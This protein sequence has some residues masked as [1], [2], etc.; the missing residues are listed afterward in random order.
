[1]LRWAHN[2]WE[3]VMPRKV[4]KCARLVEKS[5][6]LIDSTLCGSGL[7]PLELTM[8]PKNGISVHCIYIC[9]HWNGVWFCKH[10][11][12]LLSG[13]HHGQQGCDIDNNVI[14]DAGYT[15]EVNSFISFLLKDMV[16][17][18]QTKGELQESISTMRWVEGCVQGAGMLKF[19]VCLRQP[20]WRNIWFHS[21]W[22]VHCPML[23]CSDMGT[24][25]Q[26][27]G[28]LG[29]STAEVYHSSWSHKLM[30]SPSGWAHLLLLWCLAQQVHQVIS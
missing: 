23:G 1:M 16:G 19:N 7:R 20:R 8:W 2:S 17:L 24:W 6:L 30:S 18:D 11:L 29:L 5:T 28:P 15:R 10:I 27:W 13:L 4:C 3:T 21:T 9:L 22:E 12:K 14:S 25:W 26:D